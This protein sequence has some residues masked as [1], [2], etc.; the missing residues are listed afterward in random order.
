MPYLLDTVTIIR[1][2]TNNGKIGKKA[3]RALS[4]IEADQDIAAISVGSLM[5]IMYLAE[6]N[7]IQLN[8][9]ETLELIEKSSNYF[10]VDLTPEILK[11]ATHI[12]FPELHDRLILAT[13]YY[14]NVPVISGDRKFKNVAE[15]STIW[16]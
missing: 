6:R 2:F 14:L 11:R 15:V 12:A 13:A 3:R 4:N 1:H 16:D 8:L 9:T 10:V 7:R 5:G